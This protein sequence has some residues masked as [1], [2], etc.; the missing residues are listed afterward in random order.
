M[1][2]R[3]LGEDAKRMDFLDREREIQERLVNFKSK[4]GLH[5]LG[6]DRAFRRFWVFDSV[7]GLFVEHDDDD[8]GCCREDP[9]PWNPDL[10]VAPLSEEQATKKARE[11]ME[12]K[13]LEVPGSPSSD[14]ENKSKISLSNGNIP[15][16]D[17]GKTYS[18]KTPVL[19]QNV[20]G[21]N[22]GSLSV[23]KTESEM[24]VSI[25]KPWGLC[26]GPVPECPVHFDVMP[27]ITWSYYSSSEDIEKLIQSLNTRGLREGELRDK[28]VAE[29]ELIEGRLKKCKVDQYVVSEEDQ[30]E[31]TKKELQNVENRRNKQSKNT[32]ADPLPMGTGLHEM[33]ELSLRDQILELEEKIFFGN[34]GNL[35]VNSRDTW[36]AAITNKS[37][38]M[39]TDHIVW[40]EGD[41]MDMDTL[42]ETENNVVQ[43]LAAA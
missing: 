27:R 14:K 23:Q 31:I 11:I 16:G 34:L 43:Q 1:G 40:G 37:Y 10:V 29:K 15:V 39:D 21:T 22:N 38:A 12:A 17:V 33:I 42:A 7:P 30:E 5:C 24:E 8:I 6:R 4:F 41:K 36:V 9:T 3:D 19:K 32:G 2:S 20:L 18:K 13:G 26:L 25:E 28:I 35:K